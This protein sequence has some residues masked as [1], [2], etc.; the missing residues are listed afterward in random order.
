[1]GYLACAWH[2]ADAWHT[3]GPSSFCY[4]DMERA[5]HRL[6]SIV[7]GMRHEKMG[8]LGDPHVG[9]LGYRSSSRTAIEIAHSGSPVSCYLS[10]SQR[11]S[12]GTEVTASLP[13]LQR[14]DGT[15]LH[16][17]DQ[18]V[19]EELAGVPVESLLNQSCSAA[20]DRQPRRHGMPRRIPG[21]TDTHSHTA[22]TR[23]CTLHRRRCTPPA[24]HG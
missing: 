22:R 15:H 12:P 17:G 14:A 16:G 13:H 20:R 23:P 19:Q 24:A 1:M 6:A 9:T 18:L 4:V 2:R 10:S 8:N 11:L 5:E 21:S 7:G 3:R